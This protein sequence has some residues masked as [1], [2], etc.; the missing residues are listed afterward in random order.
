M[1][2]GEMIREARQNSGLS[3]SGLA[4]QLGVTKV[5][6]SD[7]ERG[8]RKPFTQ[9]RIRSVAE[10]LD[11]D[12]AELSWKAADEREFVLLPTEDCSGPKLRLAGAISQSW[13]DMSDAR[14]KSVLNVI[15]GD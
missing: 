1:L 2:F 14:A 12:V 4:T 15:T 3:L 5:Y 10:I 6:V 8:L 13:L 11:L 7:V 9:E